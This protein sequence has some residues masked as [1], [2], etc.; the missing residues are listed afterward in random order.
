[1]EATRMLKKKLGLALGIGGALLMLTVGSAT[2]AYAYRST[3][4]GAGAPVVSVESGPYGPVLVVGGTG[5][6]PYP[7]GS[8]LYYPT[9]DPPAFRFWFGGPYQAGCT[10]IE[11]EGTVEGTKSCTGLETDEQA[12]WPALTT[13]GRPVA[14]PGVSQWLLGSVY[15]ADL[16]TNQVTYAGHPLYLFFPE[17][18]T[19]PKTFVGANFYE[20]VLPLPPEH[21]AWRLISPW[22]LPAPGRATLKT[23]EPQS[24]TTYTSNELATIM[25]PGF[26]GVAVTVYSFSGDRPWQSRCYGPCATDFIPVITN[27]APTTEGVGGHV[28]VIPRFDGTWQVTYNG[29]PL[30]IYSQEE[31]LPGAPI[32][33]MGTVGNGNGVHAF[34]GTFSVV[35]P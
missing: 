11:V 17:P 3:T 19:E 30:Y 26:G 23:E 16:G 29:H 21:T 34:G 14:G 20:T 28:G 31:P 10:T 13:E 33:N 2:S 35:S 9:I 22:G 15:R 12:D 4:S 27:G 6:G 8:S 18:N 7:A 32:G 24:G 1:M 5:A 25:L